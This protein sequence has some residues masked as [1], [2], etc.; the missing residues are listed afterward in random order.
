ML[1]PFFHSDVVRVAFSSSHKA[2]TMEKLHLRGGPEKVKNVLQ[3]AGYR[4]GH[5]ATPTGI[6]TWITPPTNYIGTALFISYIVA[7]LLLTGSIIFRDV[8]PRWQARA[9]ESR[10]RKHLLAGLAMSSFSV[11]SINMISFLLHSFFGYVEATGSPA[12]FAEIWSWMLNSNLFTTFARSLLADTYVLA[13]TRQALFMTMFL[14]AVM[15]S[16]GKCLKAFRLS[17]LD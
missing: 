14:G 7:A 1:L 12:T 13:W 17:S 3:G 2:F 4:Y 5:A 15:A 16:T 8:L 9:N 6:E 10:S 11:L